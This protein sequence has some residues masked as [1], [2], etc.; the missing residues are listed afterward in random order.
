MG[1]SDRV[2]IEPL[3]DR[4]PTGPGRAALRAYRS[5]PVPA[6]VHATVRWWSA[7]FPRIA[8]FLPPSGRVLEIGCGHGLFSTYAALAG[9]ER[10]VLGVDIDAD[11]IA[12]ARQVA[13][14]LPTVD[15][16]FQVAESGAVPEGPWDAIVIVDVLYLLPADAQRALLSDAARQ[17]APGGSLLVKEMSPTPRWK[18][19]WNRWQETLAVTVL[20]I[21][22]RDPAERG[23]ARF[24]FVDPGTMACWLEGDGLTT[25][26]QRLDRHRLHPH[27]L[28]LGRSGT[29]DPG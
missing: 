7:P 28:L 10:S 2:L 12:L 9:P 21:T 4:W 29:S 26:R 6:R 16:S 18:A 11:K 20:G 14:R 15:L 27:H 8:A 24:V 3:A 17:L 5:L 25:T 19:T 23:A 1:H 22:E 13:A